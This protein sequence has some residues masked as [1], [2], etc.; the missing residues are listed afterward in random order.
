MFRQQK[1]KWYPKMCLL[2]HFEATHS[3]V[4]SK[5]NSLRLKYTTLLG[6]P[7]ILLF[8]VHAIAL[9]IVHTKCFLIITSMYQSHPPFGEKQSS[10]SC[11]KVRLL[12]PPPLQRRKNKKVLI[13]SSEEVTPAV[14]RNLFFL[15]CRLLGDCW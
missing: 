8:M 14:V 3:I 5:A 4:A 10:L 13:D 11:S 2:T 12:F 9:E 6:V 15:I 7:F 1:N